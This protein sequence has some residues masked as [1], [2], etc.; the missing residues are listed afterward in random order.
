MNKKIKIHCI[1][2]AQYQGLFNVTIN[3]YSTWFPVKKK[4][5]FHGLIVDDIAWSERQ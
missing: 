3:Y 5:N 1:D 2:L 4:K